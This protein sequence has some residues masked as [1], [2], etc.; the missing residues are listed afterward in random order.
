MKPFP[1]T[2]Q[3]TSTHIWLAKLCHVLLTKPKP[4]RTVGY[5]CCLRP[6]DSA[7]ETREE[8]C[9]SW[10]AWPPTPTQTKAEFCHQM[11]GWGEMWLGRNAWAL[12]FS[13][14]LFSC[15]SVVLLPPFLCLSLKYWDSLG[16][17]LGPLSFSMCTL[18]LENLIQSCGFKCHLHAG[19]P[20]NWYLQPITL[21]W[22]PH[23]ASN[24]PLDSSLSCLR[25]ISNMYI[26][27]WTFNF[28]PNQPSAGFPIL[29]NSTF[30]CPV[31][32]KR[33]VGV[34]LDTYFP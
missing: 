21:L 11:Q 18:C 16:L 24:Y 28:P 7:P 20:P 17:S 9:F 19:N 30:I 4:A 5:F 25:S 34:S 26:Q 6:H 27:N 1:V 29:V 23:L 22:A 32:Q 10:R 2:T 12:L 31:F 14:Y 15:S 13:S 8:L 33:C 3:W